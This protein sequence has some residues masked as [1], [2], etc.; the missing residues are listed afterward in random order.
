[1]LQSR[2]FFVKFL[3]NDNLDVVTSH[4]KAGHLCLGSRAVWFPAVSQGNLVNGISKCVSSN[5]KLHLTSL[6]YNQCL[7]GIRQLCAF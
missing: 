2:N 6:L 7:Q 3:Y 5:G 1:M 4:V